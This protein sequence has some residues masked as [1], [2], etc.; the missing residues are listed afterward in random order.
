MGPHPSSYRL[1][2]GCLSIF[3]FSF[4]IHDAPL[5]FFFCFLFSPFIDCLISQ[6]TPCPTPLFFFCWPLKGGITLSTHFV[7]VCVVKGDVK[8]WGVDSHLQK[9]KRVGPLYRRVGLTAQK[10]KKEERERERKK[11]RD[12]Y[13][14][15]LGVIGSC[16]VMQGCGWRVSKGVSPLFFFFRLKV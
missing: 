10:K 11:I 13:C 4:L 1:L 16:V 2:S 6:S 7:C 3:F 9:K 8:G 14:V 15:G 5:V 12:L